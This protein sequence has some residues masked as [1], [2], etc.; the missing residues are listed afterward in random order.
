MM[1]M[2]VIC[3]TESHEKLVKR[4]LEYLHLFEER[5]HTQII[6]PN[7]NMIISAAKLIPTHVPTFSTK[8]VLEK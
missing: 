5:A 4:F 3:N 1:M 7:I 8:Q 2:C 6:I